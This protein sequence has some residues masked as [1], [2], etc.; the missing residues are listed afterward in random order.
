MKAFTEL[1]SKSLSTEKL[2]LRKPG[3]STNALSKSGWLTTV[4]LNQV[5]NRSRFN[6]FTNFFFVF[7][8]KHTNPFSVCC[9][10]WGSIAR[11]PWW[12]S[13]VNQT[14]KSGRKADISRIFSASSKPQIFSF[15]S[16]DFSWFINSRHVFPGSAL[17]IND[18]PIRIQQ[19]RSVSTLLWL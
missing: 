7:M 3:A 4:Q 8:D 10:N 5:H 2:S 11:K 6:Y 18:C 12:L 1:K 16:H 13:I 19:T 14:L 15:Q 17:C 9:C